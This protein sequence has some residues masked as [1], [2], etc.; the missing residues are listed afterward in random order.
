MNRLRF[1]HHNLQTAFRLAPIAA[2]TAIIADCLLFAFPQNTTAQPNSSGAPY[3]VTD[4]VQIMD[5]W[6]MDDAN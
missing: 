4:G 1:R 2:L 6:N 5:A 3:I